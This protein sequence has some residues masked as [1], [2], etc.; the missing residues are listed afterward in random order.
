MSTGQGV[1]AELAAIIV[2]F[3]SG[4]FSEVKQRFLIQD[5]ELMPTVMTCESQKAKPVDADGSIQN[6]QITS[7]MSTSRRLA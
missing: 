1:T 4:E 5:K 2:V 7:R 6:E 3:C